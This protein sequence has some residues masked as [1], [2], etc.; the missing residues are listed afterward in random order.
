MKSTR[1][2]LW[3]V[4][5]SDRPREK[6]ERLGPGGLTDSELVALVLGSGLPGINVLD[7]AAS[8]LEQ[9]GGVQELMVMTVRELKALMG[10][11]VATAGRVVAVAELWR[12]AHDPL[13]GVQIGQPNDIVE[14]VRA[15]VAAR[16]PAPPADIA[17]AAA[18]DG[19]AAPG[20]A[21][22]DAAP[23]GSLGDAAP[24]EASGDETVP[25]E[26][27]R[28]DDAPGESSDDGAMSAVGQTYVVVADEEMRVRVVVPLARSAG[29]SIPSLVPR[30]LH[31]VLY[32]GGA[33]FALAILEP[34]PMR[35]LSL[36]AESSTE[37]AERRAIRDVLKLASSTVGLR[38]LS[39]VLMTPTSW[40]TVD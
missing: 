18:T 35:T 28:G 7:N 33:A 31:E 16:S 14:I 5:P 39:T 11:G 9:A 8:L 6:L 25:R 37:E 34:E 19:G 20:E 29:E 3:A 12:R 2:S 23:V 4:A 27:S 26:S 36:H 30:V 17:L 22:G 40:S 21:S 13:P 24:G 15:F 32:R 1:E 10:V 38:Y